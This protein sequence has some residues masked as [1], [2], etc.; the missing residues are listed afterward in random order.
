MLRVGRCDGETNVWFKIGKSFA[1]YL[2]NFLAPNKCKPQ[3]IKSA[4]HK[5]LYDV[6]RYKLVGSFY[7]QI[8]ILNFKFNPY[9]S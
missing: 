1:T 9:Y 3:G 8:L 6:N 4:L 2:L 5:V 7:F